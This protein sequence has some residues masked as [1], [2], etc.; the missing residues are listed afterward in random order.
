[1][2]CNITTH[3]IRDLIS[4]MD[5]VLG[6]RCCLAGM[7][8]FLDIIVIN[9]VIHILSFKKWFDNSDKNENLTKMVQTLQY[10]NEKLTGKVQAIEK[11]YDKLLE[12]IRGL[13]K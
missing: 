6:E 12:R 10:G 1:M 11:G 2:A 3:A 4:A 7:N 5:A 13:E 8:T 9:L